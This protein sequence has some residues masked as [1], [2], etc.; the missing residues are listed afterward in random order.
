MEPGRH[1][2]DMARR[3]QLG[4]PDLRHGFSLVP[5][6][7]SSLIWFYVKMEASGFLMAS[8]FFFVIALILEV[9]VLTSPAAAG[10]V[11]LFTAMTVGLGLLTAYGVWAYR[12]E[13][14]KVRELVAPRRVI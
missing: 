6:G 2:R 12:E 11:P 10:V 8:S 1:G 5:L 14:R 4:T 7:T 3:E 13:K 9:I